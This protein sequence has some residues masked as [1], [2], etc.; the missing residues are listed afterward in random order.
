MDGH[1]CEDVIDYRD[2]IFLPALAVLD[3]YVRMIINGSFV[4]GPVLPDGAFQY[5]QDWINGIEAQGPLL[6]DGSFCQ[7]G[8]VQI[9]LSDDSPIRGVVVNVALPGG[10]SPPK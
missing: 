8:D 3:P 5:T 7:S 4:H 10:S 9:T 2:G 1:E 6:P